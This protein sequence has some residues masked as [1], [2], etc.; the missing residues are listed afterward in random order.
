MSSQA[1]LPDA[2]VCDT[3]PG[4]AAGNTARPASV[5]PAGKPTPEAA[6]AFSL[7]TSKKWEK[8]ASA[9]VAVAKGTTKDDAGNQAVATY[10]LGL[11]LHELELHHA[12]AA[13]LGAIASD[14]SHPR[15]L[16]AAVVMSSLA[17]HHPNPPSLA[18]RMGILRADTLQN[19]E[20]KSSRDTLAYLLAERLFFE[21]DDEHS[22][23]ALAAIP[24]ESPWFVRGALR[25]SYSHM[26]LRKS[27]PSVQALERSLSR[28]NEAPNAVDGTRL[29]NLATLSTGWVYLTAA[30]SGSPQHDLK[31]DDTK[32]SVALKSL[33]NVDASGE[34]GAEAKAGAALAMLLSGN[35]ERAFEQLDTNPRKVPDTSLLRAT[36]LL[37][38]R[39]NAEAK[40]LAEGFQTRY[41]EQAVVAARMISQYCP[42]AK[43]TTLDELLRRD[44]SKAPS[45]ERA[46]L[47]LAIAARPVAR[48][49]EHQAAVTS[50]RAAI[51]ARL[52]SVA[53][54]TA[55][56]K[57]VE[58]S[59]DDELR[60]AGEDAAIAALD[61]LLRAQDEAQSALQFNQRLL[62]PDSATAAQF[63]LERTMRQLLVSQL[64][65]E[66][67]AS[68]VD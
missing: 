24:K 63:A 50:E 58:A 53:S 10:Q 30:V 28:L 4:R 47:E 60:E 17:A 64:R 3:H 16:D 57:V 1:S 23:E 26:R 59:L 62:G 46:L 11:V 42:A 52:K 38:A 55:L 61:A 67:L 43:H 29:R 54:D 40:A 13:I 12:S 25:A 65:A 48:A 9:L 45:D 33:T 14:P 51:G 66:Y 21:G 44:L 36:V 19:V 2:V 35:V 41:R 27:V 15:S 8:A 20:P 32:L 39:K 7:F 31:V 5:P 37:S 49:L 34:W 22:V 6:K 18:R 56:V 68:M